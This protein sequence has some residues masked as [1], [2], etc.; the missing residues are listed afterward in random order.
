MHI[1]EFLTGIGKDPV[2]IHSETAFFLFKVLQ[3]VFLHLF[4]KLH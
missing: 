4:P 1:C 3:E 2:K